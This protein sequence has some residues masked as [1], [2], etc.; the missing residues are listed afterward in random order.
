MD[1]ASKYGTVFQAFSKLRI[2]Q[3]YD[4]TMIE[5]FSR[6]LKKAYANFFF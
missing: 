6:G 1:L 4:V 2:P 5:A 3:N